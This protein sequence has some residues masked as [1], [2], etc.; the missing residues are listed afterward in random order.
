MQSQLADHRV[1][2]YHFKGLNDD[3]KQQILFERAQQVRAKQEQDEMQANN[4][5]MWAIQQ[6][7]LRRMQVLADR[8]NKR[9]LRG[10]AE[11]V[12]ETHS[13]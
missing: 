5:K 9:Q 12:K 7:Q 6:E 4:D 11:T 3:Q 13:E 10:V 1:K 2:P 8:E